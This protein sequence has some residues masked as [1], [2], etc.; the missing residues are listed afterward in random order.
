ME[1]KHTVRCSDCGSEQV[2]RLQEGQTIRVTHQCPDL[3]ERV[4]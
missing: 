4:R 1:G 3:W 2:Y